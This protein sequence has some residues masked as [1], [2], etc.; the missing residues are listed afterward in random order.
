MFLDKA[1]VFVKAGDGGSGMVAFRREKYVPAGGPAGGDGGRGGD[2]VFEADP[3]LSTLVHFQHKKKFAAESGGRGESANK[4]GRDGA[5]QVVK[6]PL[7][8]VVRRQDTH[9]VLADLTK[10]G[11]RLIAAK[12]GRGG[13]G[14]SKFA[15]PTRQAPTFAERGRTGPSYWLELELKLIADVG[16]VGYPNAGKSTLI[17]VVSRARP[18]IASYPFT[19]MEPNLGVVSLGDENSF[20]LADIP[21]IIDGAHEGVGLGLD[22]LRHIE[23]TLLILHVI[24]AAGVDGRDPLDD[25]HQ[26]NHEL[27]SFSEVLAARPQIVAANKLDLPEAQKNASRLKEAVEADGRD[28]W[29]ISA[30]SQQGVE[31]LMRG[32]FERLAA[33]RAA[34]PQEE[35]SEDVIVYEPEQTRTPLEEYTIRRDNE[36]FVVE[37]AGL[38]GMVARLDLGNDDAVRYLQRTFDRIGL[39][40]KLRK[41]GIS[42]GT[43]V[44]VGELE[45]EFV[46]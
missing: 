45:F 17:S 36:A 3:N 35:P 12:G 29:A 38:E 7:G 28:F 40:A 39:Y 44:R 19:T 41:Q 22:F 32:V 1:A 24:D 33:E 4:Y 8:T 27:E 46:E 25:Y 42:E 13:R 30:V 14:N 11:Q 37:G 18:K 10:P 2:V 26:I 15:S 21:G 34:L 6:V 23:R 16:L 31:E 20:V 9:E 5:D 43:V